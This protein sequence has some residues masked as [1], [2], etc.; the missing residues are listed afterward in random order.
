MGCDEN[1]WQRDGNCYNCPTN[2]TKVDVL[3]TPCKTAK[4]K[5]TGKSLKEC[6]YK[7]GSEVHSQDRCC[8][9][10]TPKKLDDGTVAN[11]N[12]TNGSCHGDKQ[13]HGACIR[14]KTQNN[15]S[16]P[17]YCKK[18]PVYW[19]SSDRYPKGFTPMKC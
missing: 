16:N 7:T 18:Y 5:Y 1:Q 3:V 10:T 2:G 17:Y 15:G 14:D 12:R 11:G 8:V 9:I 4:G 19:N 13:C 6:R